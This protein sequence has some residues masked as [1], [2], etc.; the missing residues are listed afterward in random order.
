MFCHI[1]FVLNSRAISDVIVDLKTNV[2]EMTVYLIDQ[3]CMVIQHTDSMME[4]EISETS[5]VK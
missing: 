1:Y 2:S 5:V 4:T 3:P